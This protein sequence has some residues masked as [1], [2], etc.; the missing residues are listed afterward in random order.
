MP[1]ASRSMPWTLQLKPHAPSPSLH[2]SRPPQL[3]AAALLNFPVVVTEQYP[4]AF[5]KTVKELASSAPPGTA[6]VTKTRFSMVVP[7]VEQR[8]RDMPHVKQVVLVGIEAHVCVLQTTLDLLQAGYEVHLLMDG[9][10]SQHG[11]DRAVAL[12]RM[13]RAGAHLSTSEA[14]LF[15]MLRDAQHPQLKA[16]SALVRMFEPRM[17]GSTCGVWVHQ[18]C[19][20]GSR[21]WRGGQVAA[22]Q[23]GVLCVAGLATVPAKTATP[24]CGAARECGKVGWQ[25]KV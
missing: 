15:Q 20:D 13:A 24:E 16:V 8:L 14:A 7:E 18:E 23:P 4:K 19:V 6:F 17:C 3:Q 22:K 21:T 10:S 1:P 2:R 11:H 5:G 25:Q 9:L 12:K